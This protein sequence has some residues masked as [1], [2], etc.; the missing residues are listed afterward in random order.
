MTLKCDAKFD[1]KLTRGFKNDMR[2]LADFHHSTP[3]S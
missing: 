3:N 1:E 2:N